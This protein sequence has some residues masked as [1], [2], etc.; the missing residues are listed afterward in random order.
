MLGM[1]RSV[2]LQGEAVLLV[3][4]VVQGSLLQAGS[5]TFGCFYSK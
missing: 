5:V 2:C 4:S 1:D 3:T